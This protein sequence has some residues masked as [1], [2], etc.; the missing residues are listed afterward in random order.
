MLLYSAVLKGVS[1]FLFDHPSEVEKKNPGGVM[2]SGVKP[3]TGFVSSILV[4]LASFCYV[5]HL[6]ASFFFQVTSYVCFSTCGALLHALD[7]DRACSVV[8]KYPRWPRTGTVALLLGL[9]FWHLADNV[10]SVIP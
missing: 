3:D 6:T 8:C 4:A 1:S 7:V 2:V 10:W 5:Q 9:V